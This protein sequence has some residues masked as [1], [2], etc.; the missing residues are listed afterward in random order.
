MNRTAITLQLEEYHRARENPRKQREIMQLFLCN[1]SPWILG[2]R[3]NF[4]QQAVLK[5]LVACDTDPAARHLCFEALAQLCRDELFPFT[6]PQDV[7][8]LARIT[9]N[10]YFPTVSSKDLYLETQDGVV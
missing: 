5:V 9:A 7:D 10:T 2:M 6:L 4:A 8:L 3:G 1:I